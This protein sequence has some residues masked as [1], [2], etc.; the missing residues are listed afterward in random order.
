MH[1]QDLEKC[2]SSQLLVVTLAQPKKK[3]A[4]SIQLPT[5]KHFLAEGKEKKEAALN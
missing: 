2:C 3:K 4:L 5:L 1:T